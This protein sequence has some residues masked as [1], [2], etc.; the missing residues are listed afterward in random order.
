MNGVFIGGQ[1]LPGSAGEFDVENPADRTVIDQVSDGGPAEA[2]AAVDAAAAALPA[3]RALPPRQR[4]EILPRTTQ[5]KDRD[6]DHIPDH[7]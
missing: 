6:P 1:W 7:I 5:L 3:W 4:T 2:T